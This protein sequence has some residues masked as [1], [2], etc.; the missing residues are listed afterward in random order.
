MQSR[1]FH[2]IPLSRLRH[3]TVSTI[4]LDHDRVPGI[5][6]FTSD[7]TRSVSFTPGRTVCRHWQNRFVVGVFGTPN[8]DHGRS[9]STTHVRVRWSVTPRRK[10]LPGREPRNRLS[11]SKAVGKGLR[12]CIRRSTWSSER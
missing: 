10:R 3:P 5:S 4:S 6:A 11:D 1:L 8:T 2:P 7:V 9:A 12:R